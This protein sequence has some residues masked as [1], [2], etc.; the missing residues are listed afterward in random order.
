MK[1]SY[2]L[3]ITNLYVCGGPFEQQQKQYYFDI[4]KNVQEKLS[5]FTIYR[6]DIGIEVCVDWSKAIDD[7][8]KNLKNNFFVGQA[9]EVYEIEENHSQSFSEFIFNREIPSSTEI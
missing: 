2:V 9:R 6:K 8:R 5:L 7:Y 3:K 1:I 4:L